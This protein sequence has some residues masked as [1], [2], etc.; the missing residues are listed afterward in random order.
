L[1]AVGSAALIGAADSAGLDSRARTKGL[2]FGTAV[3]AEML[4]NDPATMSHVA[5]EC[6]IVV[7]EA[8]FKWAELRPSPDSFAYRRADMLMDFAARHRLQVRGH[9]LIWGAYNP[10]WLQK[11]L[12]PQNAE[13]LLTTHIRAVVG[14]FRGRLVH[15]DVVN[16]VI[17]PQDNKPL[18]LA[19]TI[20]FRTLGPAYIDLAFHA[21]ATADPLAL[22]VLNEFGVEYATDD[23]RRRRGAILSL[24]ADLKHRGVPVQALGIQGHLDA[25]RRDLDQKGLAEFCAEIAALGLKIIITEMD[26]SDRWLPPDIATRDAAV[27]AHGRAFLDAVLPNQAVLG[28]LTW[29]LSDRRSWLNESLPR[30]DGRPARALPLDQDLRRKPL[31]HALAEA[32]DLAPTR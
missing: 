24:L 31:W 2:F 23:N 14:H 32:F 12:T 29:G 28:V 10:E 22:R 8:S 5:G 15:W 17:R 11:T 7:S 9:T 20:W 19:D 26:V 13:R 18:G 3:D 21:C 4:R 27:A 16:E 30:P 1:L 6:G 25:A